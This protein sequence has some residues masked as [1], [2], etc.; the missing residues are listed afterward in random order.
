MR[1]G[2]GEGSK[3]LLVAVWSESLLP[4]VANLLLKPLKNRELY[5]PRQRRVGGRIFRYSPLW[6]Q[7]GPKRELPLEQYDRRNQN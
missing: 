1:F 5:G 7:Q 4:R 3:S 2:L 6:N